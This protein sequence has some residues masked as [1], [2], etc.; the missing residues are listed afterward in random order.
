MTVRNFEKF[1]PPAKKA[2]VGTKIRALAVGEIFSTGRRAKRTD[3]LPQIK[4]ILR[5]MLATGKEYSIY[6][7][8]FEIAVR[9][10][11]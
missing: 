3:R 7:D 9:R 10:D 6:V 8:D 2:G 4:V 1:I 11:K 5:R